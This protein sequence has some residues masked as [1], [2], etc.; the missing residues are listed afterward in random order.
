MG[1]TA[2]QGAGANRTGSAT[3]GTT[4]SE[5][6]GGSPS[7][8]GTTSSGHGGTQSSEGAGG[9]HASGGSSAGG[10]TSTSEGAGGSGNSTSRCASPTV[11]KGAQWKKT[12]WAEEA[13]YLQLFAADDVVLVRT[14]DGLN[15]GRVFLST[16]DGATWIPSSAADTDI[17]ILSIVLLGENSILAATWGNSYRSSSSGKSW[18]GMTRS[19]IV[20]DTAIRCLTKID[21]VLFAGTTGSIFKSSD[22]GNAWTEVN[23][24]LP[25]TATVLSIAGKGDTLFAGTDTSGVLVTKNGGISWAPANAGLTDTRISQVVLFGSRLF[26]V[27]LDGVFLSDDSGSSWTPDTSTIK[28]VNGYLALD[29]QLL[30]ATDGGGAYVSSD[31]GTSWSPLGSGLPEGTRVWSLAAGGTGLYAGTESGVWRAGCE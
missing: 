15:G 29:N 13:N 22:D 11:L 17:D 6:S 2:C 19:G 8:G 25:T 9:S 16:D 4:S 23:T 24:G 31:S 10:G 5:G 18:D 28:S 7:N 3:G 20:A 21:K 1:G 27:T 26:A 14:W 12:N 30:A